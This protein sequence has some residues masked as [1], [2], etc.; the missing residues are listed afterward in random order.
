M[1]PSPRQGRGRAWRRVRLLSAL[2]LVLWTGPGSQ[3]LLADQTA[4]ELDGLQAEAIEQRI[5]ALWFDAPDDRAEV[6]LDEARD[7]ASG[8]DLDGA[9]ARFERLTTG[10]PD[11]AEGWNQRAILHYLR[12]DLRASLDDIERTLRLEP[13]HF[14]ALAGRGQCLLRLDRPADA[15]EA[16][17]ASL[18]INPWSQD[19]R[20]QAEMLRNHLEQQLTPI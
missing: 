12:G 9:L 19:V 4:P 7:L 14:G 8:G 3:T 11:Y 16:F 5:W 17:E 2:L 20:R 15:L 1:R 6:L 13:R 18:A 10:F